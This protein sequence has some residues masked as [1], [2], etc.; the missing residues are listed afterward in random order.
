MMLKQL[1]R[2]FFASY[3]NQNYAPVI[4]RAATGTYPATFEIQSILFFGA[5][6]LVISFLHVCHKSSLH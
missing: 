2:K 6:L 4:T 1:V 5:F 3:G